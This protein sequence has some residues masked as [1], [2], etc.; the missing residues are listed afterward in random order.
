MSI[1]LFVVLPRK[2]KEDRKII[3]NLNNY[4]NWHHFTYNQVKEEFC[5]SQKSNLSGLI[6]K[7]PIILH[8]TLFKASNRKSDRMNVLSVIDKF[9]CDALVHYGCISDDSDEYIQS[10]HFNS[11]GIDKLNPRVE[12]EIT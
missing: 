5:K 6:L 4:P 3:L 11:D 12:I 1:P 7:T 2:T 10:H 8:Y 9:F